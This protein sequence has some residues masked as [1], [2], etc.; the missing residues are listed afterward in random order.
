MGFKMISRYTGKIA[1]ISHSKSLNS[2]KLPV[3]NSIL[4]KMLTVICLQN[5]IIVLK[6]FD[7]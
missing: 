1:Y 6:G 5:K 7:F 4:F 2:N 3:Q